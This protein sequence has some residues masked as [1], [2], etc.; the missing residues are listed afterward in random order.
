MYGYIDSNGNKGILSGI[1]DIP[2]YTMAQYTA[3]TVKPDIWICTDY[4]SSSEYGINAE[5]V[6]YDNSNSVKDILQF[7]DMA[8]IGINNVDN[9]P[10]GMYYNS[11]ANVLNLPSA[12]RFLFITATLLDSPL[13]KGQWA[14]AL[15]GTIYFRLNSGGTWGAWSAL[16]S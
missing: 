2:Q 9:L 15:S 11:Q 7:A 1:L 14:F 12:T 3:L 6:Q 10:N 13:R 5:N 16:T 4:D 8:T